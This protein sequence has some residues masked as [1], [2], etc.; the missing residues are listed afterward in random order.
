MVAFTDGMG[1]TFGEKQKAVPGWELGPCRRGEEERAKSSRR[2]ASRI[3]SSIGRRSWFYG[4][5]IL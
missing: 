5:L 1:G 2:P 4:L 3:S